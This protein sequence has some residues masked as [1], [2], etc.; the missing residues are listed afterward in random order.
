MR[1]SSLLIAIFMISLFTT[2][3]IGFYGGLMNAN[4]LGVE[5]FNRVNN[6]SSTLSTINKMYN[7]TEAS[8]NVSAISDSNYD[9][10]ANIFTGA[11]NAVMQTLTL[12]SFFSDLL[13]DLKTAAG[14]PD[15][16]YTGAMGII[17]VLVIA[18]LVKFFAGRVW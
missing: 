14:L 3:F 5:T 10:P 17:L 15:W 16:F 9:A 4:D 12:P 8:Q 7:I 11:F 18:G 1:I 6:T 2:G 13:T